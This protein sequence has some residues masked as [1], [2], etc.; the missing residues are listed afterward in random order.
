MKEIGATICSMVGELRH[1]QIT[2]NTLGN[3]LM[4]RN[5]VRGVTSGAMVVITT[6]NGSTIK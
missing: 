5:K 6:V 4:V 2:A 1:G 3:I